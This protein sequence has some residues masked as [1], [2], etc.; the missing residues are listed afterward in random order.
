[1]DVGEGY[2]QTEIGVIPNEWDIVQV[3]TVVSDFRGGASLKPSDFTKVGVKVIPKGGIVRGGFLQIA[4]EDFQFCKPAYAESHPRNCV[5]SQYTVV[6]LRELVPSGPNIGLMVQIRD[7][8]TYLLAQGCYG[9]KTNKQLCLPGFLTQLSN[10]GWYRRLVNSIMVGSTQVHIT[11]TSF[12]RVQIPLPP[13]PEQRAIAGALGDVDALLGALEKLI[14]KK[15]DLKQAAMQQLLTGKTRL[16]GFADDWEVKMFDELFQF[17]N[18]AN[19][20]RADLSPFG[21]VS[22]IHY[23]DI[24]TT[25]SAFLDCADPTLPQIAKKKVANIARVQD[26]DLVMVDASEDYAGLGKSVEIRN[27]S[28]RQIVA[29]LHT[30]LLRGDRDLL[31]HGFKGYLQFVPAVRASLVSMATGISVYGVSKN[32]VKSIGLLL[33]C[34]DEQTAIAEVLS[35]MDAEIATLEQRLAKT[36]TL[37]QGMM[38][39]LL[40]GR[41]RLI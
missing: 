23:G 16:P 17:L 15:R 35:D 19:N 1:M 26:G 12:K 33:P 20:P 9:F 32:N 41:T 8:E 30:F 11:N 39:E 6:V 3:S 24:H 14:A 5:D 27:A 13:L 18:T 22:Y 7:S 2:K 37:K 36:R 21:D 38:Q 25:A 29:G 10:T 34:V 4:E 40:T 28:G 31:A